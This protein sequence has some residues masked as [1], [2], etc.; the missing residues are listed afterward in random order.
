MEIE[1]KKG[2]ADLKEPEGWLAKKTKWVRVFETII[3]DKKND[4]LGADRVRQPPS[5]HQD[6]GQAVRRLGRPRGAANGSG[7]PAPTSR[8]CCK[9]WATPRTHAEC[10]MGGAVGKSWRLVSLPFREEYPGGRQWNLDAAQFRFQPAALEPDQTPHH[11]HWDMIF[12]HIGL[13]LTPALRDLPWAQQAN[14][15]TGADYLRA[16]VA[17]AFRDPFEPTALPLPVGQREQRQE[18]PPRGPELLVTKGVVK[19]DKALTNNNEFNGELAGAI[20]CVVEEKDITLTPGAHARI[21]EYVTARTLSIRQMR[22]GR[23]HDPQHHALDSESP[24]HKPPAP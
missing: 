9:T 21:K 23:L 8:C 19:A 14:I 22:T 11:P 5:R 16:W 1:R 15:K 4:D 6:A 12:D 20:I 2:D 3:D 7:N 13:E 24:T 17:C 10:I 18:H